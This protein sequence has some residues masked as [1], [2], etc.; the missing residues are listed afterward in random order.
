MLN[1]ILKEGRECLFFGGCNQES[2]S[3]SALS[4]QFLLEMPTIKPG[5]FRNARRY[6][7][8]ELNPFFM[9]GE[10]QDVSRCDVYKS[11]RG[12]VFFLLFRQP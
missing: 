4:Q 3:L 8:P 1:A 9:Q 5:T 2:M 10:G 12:V 7:I 6:S 11:H